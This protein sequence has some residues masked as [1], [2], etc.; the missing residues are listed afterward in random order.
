MKKYYSIRV[1]EANGLD[2]AIEKVETEDFCT[3]DELCD[4]IL[5]KKQAHEAFG[6]LV[7]ENND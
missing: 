6:R 2:E 4:K 1:V 7:I 3:Y 5:T